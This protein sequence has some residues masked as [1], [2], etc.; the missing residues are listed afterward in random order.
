MSLSKPFF[1][2]ICE[3][4]ER[5]M[6]GIDESDLVGLSAVELRKRKSVLKLLLHK[7]LLKIDVTQGEPIY[8]ITHKGTEFLRNYTEFELY[9]RHFGPLRVDV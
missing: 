9:S 4:L 2:G 5:A 1:K 3:L 7:G 8:R 6:Y